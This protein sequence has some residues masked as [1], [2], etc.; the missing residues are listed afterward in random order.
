MLT[1]TKWD[2]FGMKFFNWFASNQ[3]RTGPFSFDWRCTSVSSG[4]TAAAVH[5]LLLQAVVE[6]KGTDGFAFI[7]CVRA[8]NRRQEHNSKVDS[9]RVACTGGTR[10]IRLK[11][12]PFVQRHHRWVLYLIGI[13]L[14]G[15]RVSDSWFYSANLLG[16]I[17]SYNVVV[18]IIIKALWC[19]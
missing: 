1:P 19:L 18:Y 2:N 14:A 4:S 7:H 16:E 10:V 15:Y 11:H 17:S 12:S 3:F 13:N 9:S 8:H 5:S 6:P